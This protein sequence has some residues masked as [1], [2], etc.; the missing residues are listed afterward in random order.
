MLE[1]NEGKQGGRA[2]LDNDIQP[3]PEM[4]SKGIDQLDEQQMQEI[5]IR[6]LKSSY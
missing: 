6:A 2:I 5:V 1:G 4:S 3:S